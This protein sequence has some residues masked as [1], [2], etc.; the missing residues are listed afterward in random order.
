M[1][2]LIN[3]IE[4]HKKPRLGYIIEANKL[5]VSKMLDVAC[6]TSIIEQLLSRIVLIALNS[7]DGH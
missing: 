3:K 1:D 5:R 7:S 4:S 6:I 2:N